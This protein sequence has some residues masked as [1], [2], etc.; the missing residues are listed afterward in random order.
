MKVSPVTDGFKNHILWI[1][2]RDEVKHDLSPEGWG[3]SWMGRAHKSGQVFTW[4]C[5]TS[6]YKDFNDTRD[7]FTQT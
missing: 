5:M 7:S 4:Q 2:V 1:S 3:I 6:K